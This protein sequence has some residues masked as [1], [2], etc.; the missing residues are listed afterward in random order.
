MGMQEITKQLKAGVQSPG[1]FAKQEKAYVTQQASS[2]FDPTQNSFNVD[3]LILKEIGSK[4]NARQQKR[5]ASKKASIERTSVERVF[6]G[7]MVLPTDGN[8]EAVKVINN[9]QQTPDNGRLQTFS[10]DKFAKQ[11]ASQYAKQNPV[12]SP[13]TKSQI[14][15]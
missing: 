7:N 6:N 12:Q 14:K 8:K 5:I 3:K 15:T 4:T 9:T 10:A 11:Q 13:S 1:Q 2:L